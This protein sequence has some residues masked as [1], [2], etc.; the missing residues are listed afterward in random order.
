MAAAGEDLPAIDF[1]CLYHFDVDVTSVLGEVAQEVR[2][3]ESS[4]QATDVELERLHQVLRGGGVDQ[5][6]DEGA[7][8]VEERSAVMRGEA[9]WRGCSDLG[10][11]F[12]TSGS[13]LL[14]N[15]G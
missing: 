12:S 10:E 11:F 7:M 1:F 15:S 5:G 14:E 2:P 13:S 6:E 4:V 8:Q 9:L 3:R